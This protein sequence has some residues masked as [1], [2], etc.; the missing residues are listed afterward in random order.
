MLLVLAAVTF[1]LSIRPFMVPWVITIE[2]AAAPETSLSFLLFGG[3][4]VMPIILI[5]TCVVYW[6]IRGKVQ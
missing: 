2:K 6:V 1:F 3:V 5:Y 4:I